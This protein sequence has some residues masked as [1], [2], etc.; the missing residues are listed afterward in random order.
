MNWFWSYWEYE[1]NLRVRFLDFS[2]VI[3]NPIF[4]SGIS[5]LPLVLSFVLW[6]HY[7]GLSEV[8]KPYTYV[9]LDFVVTIRLYNWSIFIF[10]SH[11]VFPFLLPNLFPLGYFSYSLAMSQLLWYFFIKL[12][13]WQHRCVVHI[14]WNVCSFKKIIICFINLSYLFY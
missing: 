5:I 1:P 12:F 2:L 10:P 6:N 13:W 4:W 8:R 11:S 14:Y 7:W 9:P 3:Y